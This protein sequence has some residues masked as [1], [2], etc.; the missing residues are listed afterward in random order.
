MKQLFF[1][2]S[3]IFSAITYAQTPC[4]F[5]LK[6]DSSALQWPRKKEP[7]E[8]L[9]VKIKNNYQVQFI[10]VDKKNYLKIIVRDDLGFGKKGSL[11]LLAAKKQIYIRSTTLT[12]IDKTSAYFL[13]E[14]NDSYYLDNIKEF[15][16][17]KIVFNETTE[18]GIPKTDSDQIKK[19]AECF[20]N[21]VKDNIW[22]P[23][24]KL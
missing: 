22:P 8:L 3:L 6:P 24:K 15:G 16:L 20:N 14:L 5:T 1:T 21:V 7:V 18:F 19:A 2:C 17:S 4:E 13:V 10:K 11:L 23:V 12:I 9:E